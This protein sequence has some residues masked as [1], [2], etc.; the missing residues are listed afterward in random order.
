MRRIV[1][2]AGTILIQ[3]VV[4]L[5]LL[6]VLARSF[7]IEGISY[8]SET[9]RYM[10]TL[11][12]EQPIGYRNQPGLS[13]RFFGEVVEIN[14]LGLRDREIE[15]GPHPGEIRILLMGDSFPFGVGVDFEDSISAQLERLMQERLGTIDG[16]TIRTVNMGVISYNTEQQLIQLKDLGWRLK[17]DLILHI[18]VYNDI[19]S[20]MWIF[21]KRESALVK[22]VQSSYALSLMYKFYTKLAGLAGANPLFLHSGMYETS[23]PRYKATRAALSGL[24]AEAAKHSVPMVQFA[25]IGEA[26]PE[27]RALLRE[28][29]KADKFNIHWLDTWS[30]D[31][32][33]SHLSER[34][35]QAKK[36]GGHPN[37]AGG[38]IFATMI[39]EALIRE[40]VLGIPAAQ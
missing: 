14:S 1:S 32:R 23:H 34:E 17:P 12:Q 24:H 4:G 20:K 38:R 37:A 26:Y 35:I 9:A 15:P 29:S 5:V 3:I 19:E 22:L 28:A 7:D 11:V 40:G 25:L 16:K 18:Y 36:G 10:D 2:I 39:F 27:A 21:E 13:G 33:W 30:A 6:E 31:A 8:Y